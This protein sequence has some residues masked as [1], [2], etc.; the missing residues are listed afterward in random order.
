MRQKRP[1]P[2]CDREQWEIH[3]VHV[4]AEVEHAR[5]ASASE[6]SLVPRTIGLLLIDQE[7]NAAVNRAV[8]LEARVNQ[9]EQR[10][11]RL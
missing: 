5:E 8:I 4:I 1:F 9:A 10:P 2:T 6:L 7:L 3:G 11:S